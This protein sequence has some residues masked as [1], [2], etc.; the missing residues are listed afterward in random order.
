MCSSIFLINNILLLKMSNGATKISKILCQWLF[1]LIFSLV[2]LI[3]MELV[4]LPGRT[5]RSLHLVGRV[6]SGKI[7]LEIVVVLIIK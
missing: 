2:Y 5:Q 3:I 4:Q 7:D 1:I 6:K